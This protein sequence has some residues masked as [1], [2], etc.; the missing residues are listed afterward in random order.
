MDLHAPHS[1]QTNSH[2]CP[3]RRSATRHARAS[4][5]VPDVATAGEVTTNSSNSSTGETPAANGLPLISSGG[6]EPW[7][8]IVAGA[9]VP[10]DQLHAGDF[11]GDG[12]SDF[13]RRAPD[14]Q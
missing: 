1:M 5:A 3:L 10:L 8:R 13:F 12:R 2:R 4:S 7:R 14:G 11:N 9:D 6:T